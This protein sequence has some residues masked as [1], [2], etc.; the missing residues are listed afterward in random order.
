MDHTKGEGVPM[1][2]HNNSKVE[3]DDMEER[4]INLIVYD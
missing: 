1:T 2:Q 3:E 4:A